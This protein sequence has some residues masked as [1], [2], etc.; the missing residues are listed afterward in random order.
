M[1]RPGYKKTGDRP[2]WRDD[3][4]QD[5]RLAVLIYHPPMS[6]ARMLNN[7]LVTWPLLERGW[8]RVG[9]TYSWPNP[10]WNAEWPWSRSYFDTGPE[11]QPR[12]RTVLQFPVGPGQG[13]DAP[14][15][16]EMPLDSVSLL[17][18]LDVA[19]SRTGGGH[20][21]ALSPSRGSEPRPERA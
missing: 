12:S 17:V 8:A 3:A 13:A 18:A 19:A 20:P 2:D 16:P 15:E 6:Q 4:R 21:R 7:G 5:R 10:W 1:A 14:K 11:H 9:E